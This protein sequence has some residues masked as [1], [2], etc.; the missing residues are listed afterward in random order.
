MPNFDG[1]VDNRWRPDLES[2][3]RRVQQE[4]REELDELTRRDTPVYGVDLEDDVD[5]VVVHSRELS[6]VPARRKGFEP[7][8]AQTRAL[9]RRLGE[10]ERLPHGAAIGEMLSDWNWMER[11]RG[12]DEKQQFLEPVIETV[13]RE[14]GAHEAQLIFLMLVFEPVR[15]GVSKAL[16]RARS[17]LEP[18]LRDM[19]WTNRQEARMI[20]HVERERLYDI[21]R[22]AALE[23]VFRYPAPSPPRLFLWLRE[24]IAHRSLDHLTGEL[25]HVET[26][27]LLADEAAAI[28]NALAGFTAAEQPT[29]RERRGL[30]QWRLQI[31]M[32]DVFDTVEAF[33]HHDPVRDAC[34]TAV[35]RLPRAER[36]VISGYFYEELDV[37]TLANRRSVSTSTIYNQKA[38]AQ[39]TLREDNV[40]FSA[41]CSLGRVRDEARTRR[42]TA[43][44]PD[45]RLPD[46]R[47]IVVIN[48]A[49]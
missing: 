37:P 30:R 22:E 24:T 1:T 44:Y 19:S 34:Q 27:G 14:P 5:Q 8:D 15:R 18:E 40:F 48:T 7:H 25:P 6:L 16:G 21:T 17:G 11:M 29:M 28:Q 41:L 23:A 36:E 9:I 39:S 31:N 42:L 3:R 26:S 46:G 38:R 4:L 10:L 33:Y 2:S 13:R 45:G 43:T 47:R 49:A 20:A 35:G 12:A 32:R